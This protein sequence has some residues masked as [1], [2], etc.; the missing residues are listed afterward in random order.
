MAYETVSLDVS[1]GVASIKLNRPDAL[2]SLDNRMAS[3]LR[4]ALKR[5]TRDGAA[6]SLLLTGTGRAF[7]A[8]QD[9]K[10][11]TGESAPAS[12]G[13]HLRRTWNPIIASLHE[14]TKPSVAVLNGTAAGA[15]ASLA[16]ACDLRIASDKASIMLAFARVGVIPD[17]GATWTL[18]RLVGLGR[19]LELAYL[20]DPV[21]A[22]EALRLGLV[23]RVVPHDELQTQARQLARRLADGPTLTYALTKRAMRRS[24]GLSLDEA[25]EQEAQLQT[26]AGRSADYAEGVDAFV[27]KRPPTFTGR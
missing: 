27:G 25:L 13:D 24:Y 5:A 6:R 4:D 21:P 10:A 3:E 2:N 11:I 22:E 8:G 15:G 7:C 26:V 18:P 14:L 20:A 23:N 17:S 12:L 19:A 1:D 16:L 9:L